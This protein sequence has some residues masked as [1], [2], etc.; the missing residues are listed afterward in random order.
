MC[1][2]LVVVKWLVVKKQLERAL[3]RFLLKHNANKL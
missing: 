1:R 2:I 3:S